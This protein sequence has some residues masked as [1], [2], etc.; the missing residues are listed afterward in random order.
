MP[1]LL[2]VR[3]TSRSSRNE[4]IRWDGAILQLRVTAPPADGMANRAVV[5][6]VSATFRVPK[7]SVHLRAGAS[8]R[9]KV[10]VLETLEEKGLA[11]SALKTA[12]QLEKSGA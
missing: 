10:L 11:A 6:L 2:R 3:V 1:A 4:V 5:E 9:D 12:P 8:S 7:S